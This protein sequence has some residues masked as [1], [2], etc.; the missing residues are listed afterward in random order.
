M[1]GSEKLSHIPGSGI[2]PWDCVSQARISISSYS[3]EL[4]FPCVAREGA[5]WA[6]AITIVSTSEHLRCQ[7]LCPRDPYMDPVS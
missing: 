6:T 7:V 2:P 3:L 5:R 4:C 1:K